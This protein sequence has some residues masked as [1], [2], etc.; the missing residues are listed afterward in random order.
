ML[1]NY[2]SVMYYAY[3][4]ALLFVCFL[5]YKLIKKSGKV[6]QKFFIFLLALVNLVQHVFK[7]FIYPQY[8]GNY[9]LSLST[10]Y[11]FCALLIIV[12][13]FII[14]FGNQLLKNFFSYAGIICGILTF[15]FPYWFLNQSALNWEV[16]RYYICHGLLFIT[17]ILPVLTKVTKLDLKYFWVMGLLFF[18][19]LGIVLVNDIV[20]IRMGIMPSKGSLLETLNALN[21]A[22]TMHP[23]ANFEWLVDIFKSISPSFLLG[24]NPWGMYIPILW[25]AIPLYLLTVMAVLIMSVLSQLFYV[26][27]DYLEDSRVH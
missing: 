17:A 1:L 10:A 24:N 21:P 3:I 14:L 13:P 4:A 11:N 27:R 18:V 7:G 23:P 15:G 12:A 8:Q 19:G 26:F 5:C 6:L 9:D 16:Y 20:L 25:Y 2:G 22:W